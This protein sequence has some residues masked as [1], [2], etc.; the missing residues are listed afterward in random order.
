MSDYKYMLIMVSVVTCREHH[1]VSDHI[2]RAFSYHCPVEHKYTHMY[3]HTHTHTYIH[4][5]TNTYTYTYIYIQVIVNLWF[6]PHALF[7][8]TRPGVRAY[9]SNVT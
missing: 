2:P 8:S 9:K 5:H 1:R 6:H 4:V 3:I 7:L